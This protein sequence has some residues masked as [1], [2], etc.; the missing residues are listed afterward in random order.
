MRSRGIA[1]SAAEQYEFEESLQFDPSG[2]VQ[3]FQEDGMAVNET[4]QPPPGGPGGKPAMA[5]IAPL[6]AGQVRQGLLRPALFG[7]CVGIELLGELGDRRHPPLTQKQAGC[8]AKL[9]AALFAM[10]LH[11]SA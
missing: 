1:T 2:V 5:G 6:W 11:K 4:G 8:I 9:G 7:R 3:Y 10:R